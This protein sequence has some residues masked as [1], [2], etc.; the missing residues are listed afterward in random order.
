MKKTLEILSLFLALSLL[1]SCIAKVR[2]QDSSL[3]EKINPQAKVAI[4]AYDSGKGTSAGGPQAEGGVLMLIP[5]AIAY[6]A[7]GEVISTPKFNLV[8][9]SPD[10]LAQQKTPHDKAWLAN[11]E[12]LDHTMQNQDFLE[13]LNYKQLVFSKKGERKEKMSRFIKENNLD[14]AVEVEFGFGDQLENLHKDLTPQWLKNDFRMVSW[15][16]V[17][18]QD[19]KEVVTYRIFTSYS[20]P[21][22]QIDTNYPQWKRGQ[23]AIKKSTQEFLKLLQATIT[24]NEKTGQ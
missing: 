13:Y 17:F 8:L 11:F 16:R 23:I 12:M 10:L 18:N 21:E 9:V 2:Y 4:I 7:K 6:A 15:W 1:S 19:Y 3:A 20:I 22:K 5:M 24:G 14:L